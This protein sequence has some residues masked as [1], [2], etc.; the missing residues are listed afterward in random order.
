MTFVSYAQ[1]FEDVVLWR[2][3]RD[4]ERGRYLDIG[5]QDPVVD[6]VSL[7]FYNAGWRGIHV[8]PTPDYASRLRSARPDETVIEAAVA[9]AAGP[10]DFYEIPLTG[11]STGRK[12]IADGHKDAGY[13]F[14]R[15]AVPTV[16]LETLLDMAE[17]D[18]HW[19]KVD[20]EGMEAEVLRSWG[21][22]PAR[23][24][25]LVL[26]ATEP[27]T[28][29]QSHVAWIEEVI[30]RGYQEAQFDGLSRYFV[31]QDQ[32]QLA[33]RLNLPAN[34]FDGFSIS[35]NHFS[36][37]QLASELDSLGQALKGE[38]ER[39]SDLQ[40]RL[41]AM[42]QALDH[43]AEQQSNLLQN[44][45]AAEKTHRVAMEAFRKSEEELRKQLATAEAERRAAHTHE[46]A[47]LRNL[48]EAEQ[49]RR[50]AVEALWREFQDLQLEARKESDERQKILQAKIRAADA[51]LA[52]THAEL[53]RTQ[54]RAEML[55][56][57]LAQRDE[58]ARDLVEEATR[59]QREAAELRSNIEVVRAEGAT[60][61]SRLRAELS[62]AIDQLSSLQVREQ[63]DPNLAATS[64]AELLS[65]DDLDFVRCAYATLL[66]RQPDPQGERYYVNRIRTGRAKMEIIRD[67]RQSQEGQAFE[68]QTMGMDQ[69][70]RAWR[71]SRI[72]VLG[73]R[74]DASRTW[75]FGTDRFERAM[76]N[77]SHLILDSARAAAGRLDAS[78]DRTR[79]SGR[80]GETLPADEQ[81]AGGRRVLTV[82]A[83]IAAVEVST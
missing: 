47:C 60:R 10:I 76:L 41:G 54:E 77:H 67:L 6:S 4:V 50:E 29:V 34:I 83:L 56:H 16:R 30:G 73:R 52:T 70:I 19:M 13:A 14:N 44:S 79:Y 36:A 74:Y 71:F 8:E 23:P 53:A 22:S 72:P 61:E 46:Q 42:Q 81:S 39:A 25:I 58:A 11:L 26:E 21:D 9:D 3:L 69:A 33:S 62:A 38:Q 82:E 48:V 28:Q 80:V 27:N 40:L 63:R 5:A 15:L 12:R 45:A 2:A 32:R 18:I 17:G 49:G 78:A 1:N 57:Q 75:D 24:W 7:A 65:L 59:L 43:A 64:L 51:K 20:V 31:H 37:G 66:G 35:R 68:P 55:A